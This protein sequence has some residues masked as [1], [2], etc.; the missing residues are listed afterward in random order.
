MEVNNSNP[1]LNDI[2]KDEKS[3]EELQSKC[4]EL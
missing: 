3:T 1:L 2:K 4:K